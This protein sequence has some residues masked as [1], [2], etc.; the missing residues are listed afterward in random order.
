M[1]SNFDSRKSLEYYDVGTIYAFP[2]NSSIAGIPLST[3]EQKYYSKAISTLK[4]DKTVSEVTAS[5][6]EK[7]RMARVPGV[8]IDKERDGNNARVVVLIRCK[9]EGNSEFQYKK[10]AVGLGGVD[11]DIASLPLMSTFA[12]DANAARPVLG[13]LKKAEKHTGPVEAGG[14]SGLHTGPTEI[15]KDG[16][17]TG[18]VEVTDGSGNHTGPVEYIAKEKHTGPTEA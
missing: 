15:D 16:V 2:V 1:I 4:S 18:P 8:I 12:F 10:Y 14:Q 9:A 13:Q 3:D 6:A 17:H 7:I 11:A 5:V